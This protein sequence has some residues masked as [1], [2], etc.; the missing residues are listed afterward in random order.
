MTG[1]ACKYK[2]KVKKC[3]GKEKAA[4][5][6]WWSRLFLSVFS[7]HLS[8]RHASR[9]KITFA[10]AVEYSTI[11][12]RAPGRGSPLCTT[13]NRQTELSVDYGINGTAN[14][15]HYLYCGWEKTCSTDLGRHPQI[16][17]KLQKFSLPQRRFQ[18]NF[19]TTTTNKMRKQTKVWM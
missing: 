1:H 11:I 18:R 8:V 10:V 19:G 15:P 3:M 9:S 14:L 12:W 2:V 17:E 6:L 16:R 13:G 4:T 5:A 7:F